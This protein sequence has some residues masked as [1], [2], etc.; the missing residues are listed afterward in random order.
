VE[1]L[2]GPAHVDHPCG[3]IPATNLVSPGMLIAQ[4]IFTICVRQVLQLFGRASY[5]PLSVPAGAARRESLWPELPRSIAWIE[6]EQMLQLARGVWLA[7][8]IA[9]FSCS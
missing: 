1:Y 8:A 3:V 7:N 4:A 2:R 9:Q 5:T 6:V